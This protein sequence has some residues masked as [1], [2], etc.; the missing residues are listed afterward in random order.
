[1]NRQL[2]HLFGLSGMKVGVITFLEFQGQG[3][4]YYQGENKLQCGVNI[5]IK[6]LTKRMKDDCTKSLV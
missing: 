4:A 5:D 2:N 3:H 1:M 6:C